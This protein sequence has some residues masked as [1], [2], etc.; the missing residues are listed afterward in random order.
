MADAFS[1]FEVTPPPCKLHAI[2][3]RLL[4]L[5]IALAAVLCIPFVIWGGKFEAWFSGEA[6]VAW[7]RSWGAWGWAAVVVLLVSDLVLPI[8]ATPLM[9]AAGYVFGTFAGGLAGAA[10]SFAAG[11]IG[12]SLCRL[13]GQ[14][15]AHR[16][17]GKDALAG[18]EAL[19]QRSG[20]WIVAAS[21]WMPLLPE[22]VS[23]LAGLTRMPVRVFAVSLACGALPMGF[24]F[25][26]IGSAGRA[27]PTLAITLSALVPLLLWFA[28]RPLLSRAAS[29]AKDGELG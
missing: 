29:R 11:M 28:A 12:Y 9:S 10:G 6:A 18:H 8:P 17:A 13:F 20:P 1:T 14:K 2:P 15:V 22:V 23:C 25:A 4:I 24:A 3:M 16:L 5:T 19:F 27:N 7:I 26:A 21:R